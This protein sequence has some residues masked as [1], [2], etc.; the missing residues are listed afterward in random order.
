[1]PGPHPTDRSLAAFTDGRLDTDTAYSVR[2]HVLDCQRCLLRL[3]SAQANALLN[4]HQPKDTEVLFTPLAEVRDELPFSGDVWRLAWDDTSMLAVVW[5][6][7]ADR[8]G[9]LPVVE[10]AD[11]D[12][13]TAL[14][15][16]DETAGMGEIAV[17][18]AH[19]T[20]VPWAVLDARIVQLPDVE[21]LALLRTAYRTGADAGTLA[22]G[23]PILSP[24]DDRL[25]GSDDLAERL[26]ILANAS[27]LPASTGVAAAS[28]TYEQLYDAGLPANRALAISA[29]GSAPSEEEAVRIEAATGIR[30]AS[31]PVDDELRRKIDSPFRK[32]KIMARARA[33][34]RSEAQERLDLARQAEPAAIAARGTFG[35]ALAYDDVLNR[36]LSD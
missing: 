3:G 28:F 35:R 27:W 20:S 22:H 10:I 13:W 8:I 12:E 25:V 36:L 18:V 6:A 11:A 23:E 26:S 29:R 21:P 7:D 4:E 30:P 24:L 2:S 14:L 31:P 9:V 5:R 19:E 16:E 32:P 1:M 15:S 34:R 33:N 17:A